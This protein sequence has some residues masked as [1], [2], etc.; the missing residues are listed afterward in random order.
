M[1]TRKTAFEI[2]WLYQQ[3]LHIFRGNSNFSAVSHVFNDFFNID[4]SKIDLKRL[5]LDDQ[6]ASEGFMTY[7]FLELSQ[8][9]YTKMSYTK[10][11]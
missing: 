1:V 2:D 10:V 4:Y 8:R 11:N 6:R 3:T 7:W 5:E 9:S